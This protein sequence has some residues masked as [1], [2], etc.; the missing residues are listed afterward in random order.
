MNRSFA[1]RE[2]ELFVRGWNGFG[3]R[4]NILIFGKAREMRRCALVPAERVTGI[5]S[6][7]A[8]QARAPRDRAVHVRLLRVIPECVG[9]DTQRGR[10]RID[11]WIGRLDDHL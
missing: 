8:E 2:I 10:R 5:L 3:N 11:E 7:P 4:T 9:D 1:A 6:A